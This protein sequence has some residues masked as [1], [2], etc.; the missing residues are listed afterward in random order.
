MRVAS[1]NQ[2]AIDVMIM[3]ARRDAAVPITFTEEGSQSNAYNDYIYNCL[4]CPPDVDLYFMMGLG[5][6][7]ANMFTSYETESPSRKS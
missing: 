4:L 6:P 2:L 7:D 3:S 5:N 1:P